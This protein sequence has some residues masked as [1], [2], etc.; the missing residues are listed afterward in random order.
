MASCSSRDS[1]SS[2]ASA[3]DPNEDIDFFFSGSSEEDDV[4]GSIENPDNHFIFDP[5]ASDDEE[6]HAVPE[7]VD[8]VDV[9]QHVPRMANTDWCTCGRCRPMDSEQESVCCRE[10]DKVAAHVP[11]GAKC[12]TSH[13]GFE[14]I[15]LNIHALQVAYYTLMED[16]PSLV[17]A[18]DIHTYVLY[19]YG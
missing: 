14:P 16:R 13:L 6:A 15:C 9:Q 3:S 11:E 7:A 17:D 12:I 8:E 1:D 19:V 4:R 5:L 10:V 18:P 2:S